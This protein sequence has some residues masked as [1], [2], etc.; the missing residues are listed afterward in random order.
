MKRFYNADTRKE[1]E[2]IQSGFR[3]YINKK[4]RIDDHKQLALEGSFT[5]RQRQII[6][7]NP[8]NNNHSNPFFDPSLMMSVFRGFD[9][10]I[11]NPPYI[12]L[13]KF[14]G[15]PIQQVY[16]N[17]GYETHDANGD[18]YCL[19][20]EL[21]IRFLKSGG[22]LTYITSNKW[23][24]AAYGEKLRIYFSHKNPRILIDL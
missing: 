20:Y 4:Y 21:G 3:N 15:N 2:D 9:I 6:E 22:H 17:V 18:I 13:Q 24:R 23:M 11:G 8:F 16:K 7:F 10:A 19:F 1:K 5:P 14:K 12:Q